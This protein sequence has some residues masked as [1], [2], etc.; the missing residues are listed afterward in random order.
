MSGYAKVHSATPV[1]CL[2]QK[3]IEDLEAERRHGKK[4]TETMLFRWFSMKVHHVCE[5]GLRLRTIYLPTL[6]SPT[7]RCELLRCKAMTVS[8]KPGNLFEEFAGGMIPFFRQQLLPRFFSYSHQKD[9]L[10]TDLLSLAAHAGFPQ[11]FPA[12]RRDGE[13][14]LGLYPMIRDRTA[15]VCFSMP[16]NSPRGYLF[17]SW[18]PLSS[19]AP[20]TLE[21]LPC[22]S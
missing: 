22:L 3:N 16:L 4:S 5:G 15:L 1:M 7:S 2:D 10:L 12:R 21:G 11:F 14:A 17:Y 20:R 18:R 6:V 8:G 9:E 19:K 13:G